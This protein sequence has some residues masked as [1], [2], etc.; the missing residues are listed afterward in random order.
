MGLDLTVSI[1]S[2]FD[3]DELKRLNY[4]VTKLYNLRNCY[5]ILNHLSYRLDNG[6]SNCATYSF[7]GNDFHEILTELQTELEE[8]TNEQETKELWYNIAKLEAFIAL[9]KVSNDSIQGYQ[10]H[11]W[12]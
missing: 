6:F 2:D 10:V 4:K 3:F 8:C 5:K 9:N 7:Y 1:Q 12:Y 11:A